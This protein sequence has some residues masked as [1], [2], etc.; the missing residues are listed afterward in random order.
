[1][2]VS[3]IP[4]LCVV[5]NVTVYFRETRRLFYQDPEALNAKDPGCV[6]TE[7]NYILNI[8]TLFY[9]SYEAWTVGKN[10]TEKLPHLNMFMA[11]F[12]QLP[13]DLQKRQ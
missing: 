12:V 10:V 13:N 2:L 9:V 3:A 6:N 8:G 4:R 11:I 1:M 5:F 7:E